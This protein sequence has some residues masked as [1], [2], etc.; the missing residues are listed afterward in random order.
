VSIVVAIVA[1]VAGATSFASIA[2]AQSTSAPG[3]LRTADLPD[4]YQLRPGVGAPTP[5]PVTQMDRTAC[6]QSLGPVAGLT[7]ASLVAFSPP[8]APTTTT[9]LNEYVLTFPTDKAAKTAYTVFAGDAAARA[10]CANVNYI[11]ADKTAPTVPS[12]YA[13][14]KVP[15]VGG[16]TVATR[17][18]TSTTKGSVLVTFVDGKHV[19]GLSFAGEPYAPSQSELATITKNAA[20][21]LAEL[22]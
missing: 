11:P 21:R 6:T 5:F 16:G 8:G 3:H 15:K 10:K 9:G 14:V 18:S 19:V 22:D 7:G 2:V 1:I 4:G 13:K 20:A 17:G 12:T